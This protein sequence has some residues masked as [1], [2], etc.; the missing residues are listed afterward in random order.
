[1]KVSQAVRTRFSARGFLDKPVAEETVREILDCA[2]HSPSGGNLQPWHVYVVMG[3]DTRRLVDIVRA[4]MKDRPDGEPSE[5]SI[6]PSPLKEPYRTRRFR[7]GMDLYDTIGIEREDRAGRR[8]QFERNYEFFGAPVGMFFYVDR[9]MGPPQWADIG[10]LL[11]TI[12]L[13]AREH[14]L[15]TCPQEAWSA[16]PQ[17]VGE[18]FGVPET[19][20]LFCGLSLGYLDPDD[21]VN[22]LRT[23]RAAVDEIATFVGGAQ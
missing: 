14:G 7:C 22:E 1:M 6:Y 12:M 20:M 8:R 18:F 9:E 23:Q 19:L 13:L 10:I 5:Y 2:R 17:T 11:Q 3:A 15:H 21:P 16:W 4:R